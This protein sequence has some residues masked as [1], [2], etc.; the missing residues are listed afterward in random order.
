M[1][2]NFDLADLR[3]FV[4]VAELNSFRA[5]AES[6]HLSQP[7]LSRRVEKLEA[8]LGIRLFDRTTRSVNLTAVGRDFSKKARALLDEL[9]DS[10]LSMRE[11]ASSQVGE[12]VIACIPSAVY[13]F[14]PQVLKEYHAQYPRIRVRII[15]DGAN[16][17]LESVTRGEADF[18]INIIGTQ[19][20]EIEFQSILSESFVVACRSDHPI[21]VKRQVT[22]AELDQYDYMTVDKSSGNRLLLDNA[23]ATAKA[24]PSWRYEARHISTL[25]GMVEAGL[26]IAVVP[27][28]SMPMGKHPTLVSIP[29]VD[30]SVERTVGL[31]RRRGRELSP[32]ARQLYQMIEKTWPRRLR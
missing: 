14:L 7:A 26:G 23:L 24:R 19:E 1:S 15:D 2:M 29:L 10:L 11:V 18:G 32:S 9:E 21:A 31:I 20:P 17:A 27:R 13:Y 4:A 8:A 16:A 12:V 28:L 5:A 6:I 25:V 22:W 30:P 3:A